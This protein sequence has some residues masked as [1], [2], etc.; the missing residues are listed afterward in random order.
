VTKRISDTKEMRLRFG[1]VTTVAAF[2]TLSLVSLPARAKHQRG[3]VA[4]TGVE[5]IDIVFDLDDTGIRWIHPGE[6][7]DGTLIPQK[8]RITQFYAASPEE[9]PIKGRFQYRV[10]DGFPE[11]LQSLAQ[12][13][14]V[15]ISFFSLGPQDRNRRVLKELKLPVGR[16]AWDVAYRVLGQNRGTTEAY[17]P[18]V[19]DP[20]TRE[21]HFVE[22]VKKNLLK[23]NP[24]LG[25]V[26]I[27]D[28]SRHSTLD[29]QLSNIAWIGDKPENFPS[30]PA[31]A[32]SIE[33]FIRYRNRMAFM[34]GVIG[35][36]LNTAKSQSIP[37]REALA[38]L[39]IETLRHD[40]DVYRE[41]AAE[42]EKVNPK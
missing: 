29:D 24:K 23:I 10:L 3:A 27:V 4:Q 32:A 26:L 31:D 7:K 28:D 39:H 18:T 30:T 8:G 36:V 12:I 42:L 19:L 33:E 6:S 21:I 2:L 20:R 22:V 5:P 13:P 9:K 35:R 16:S 40:P 1:F 38:R 15:R 17:R 14:G 11:M 34:R 25:Q 41:G 37:P